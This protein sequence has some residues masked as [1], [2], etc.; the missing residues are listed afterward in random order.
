LEIGAIGG[1]SNGADACEGRW[2]DTKPIDG[3]VAAM[4]ASGQGFRR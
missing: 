3:V 2:V 1:E 4:V